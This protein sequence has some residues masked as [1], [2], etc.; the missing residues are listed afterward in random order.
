MFFRVSH[1]TLRLPV[2]PLHSSQKNY[3]HQK[4][5]SQTGLAAQVLDI[6]RRNIFIASAVSTLW[7]DHPLEYHSYFFWCGKMVVVLN[8][9]EERKWNFNTWYLPFVIHWSVGS[10][11]YALSSE[12]KSGWQQQREDRSCIF[13]S[14]SQGNK[15]SMTFWII[16]SLQ[17]FQTLV[18]NKGHA[19]RSSKTPTLDVLK[20]FII[21]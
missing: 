3:F 10:I 14:S 8:E 2:L 17:Q 12:F 18:E 6:R 15:D 13:M 9:F 19:N 5:A 4:L 21:T 1:P 7:E 11:C 20:H 16:W